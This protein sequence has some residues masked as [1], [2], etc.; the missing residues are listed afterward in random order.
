MVKG[1][2]HLYIYIYVCV[3]VYKYIYIYIH[4]HTYSEIGTKTY[5]V[6]VRKADRLKIN[7]FSIHL[8]NQTISKYGSRK[9]KQRPN[10][11]ETKHN[12]MQEVR[13]WMW[14]LWIESWGRKHYNPRKCWGQPCYV[15]TTTY[16]PHLYR[17]LLPYIQAGAKQDP[18]SGWQ[19]GRREQTEWGVN[20]R[21]YPVPL[22]PE[23]K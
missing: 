7:A 18:Q 19:K 11:C 17:S 13:S 15:P 4:I 2:I 22:Q 6:Y 14:L 10:I 21:W 3:C 5:N 12:V 20:L 23:I 8:K 1:L 16:L 9:K